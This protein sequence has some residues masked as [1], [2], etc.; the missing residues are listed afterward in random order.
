MGTSLHGIIQRPSS[1]RPFPVAIEQE[2]KLHRHMLHSALH[3]R[4]IYG[5]HSSRDIKLH[6]QPRTPQNRM[7]DRFREA[8]AKPANTSVDSSLRLLRSPQ[9]AAQNNHQETRSTCSVECNSMGCYCTSRFYFCLLRKFQTLLPLP[10]TH[11][12]TSIL[13]SHKHTYQTYSFRSL[14]F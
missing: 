8:A 6:L 4:Q 3:N 11:L 2:R 14:S 10:P 9:D 12:H 13:V 5:P 1:S 7:K